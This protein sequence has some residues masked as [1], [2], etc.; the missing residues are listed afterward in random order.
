MRGAEHDG[1]E[2][3]GSTGYLGR[4][5]ARPLRTVLDS[6]SQAGKEKQVIPI[7]AT[8]FQHGYYEGQIFSLVLLGTNSKDV[9]LASVNTRGKSDTLDCLASHQS[10]TNVKDIWLMRL[11]PIGC[12]PVRHLNYNLISSGWC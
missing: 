9:D 1:S 10:H 3:N 11:H 5:K 8:C 7:G 12:V 2:A 4:H 6:E